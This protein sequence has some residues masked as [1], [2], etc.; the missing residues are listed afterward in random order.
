MEILNRSG[1][2]NLAGR[3]SKQSE[4]IGKDKDVLKSDWTCILCLYPTS[5]PSN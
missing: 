2:R 4:G 1:L 3:K 5:L